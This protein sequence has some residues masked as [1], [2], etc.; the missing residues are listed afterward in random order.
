MPTIKLT[1][2]SGGR[3]TTVGTTDDAIVDGSLT[4]GDAD[5]DSLVVNAEF[6][7]DLVPDD[8]NTYDLGEATKRWRKGYFD[9]V[10]A[11]I[12]QAKSAKYRREDAT[13]QYIRWDSTGSNG[14]PGV[15][16]K[17]IA[18]VNGEL[19]TVILRATGTNSPVTPPGVTS[20]GFH[21]AANGAVNLDTTAVETKTIDMAAR[22]TSY[23]VA[24]DHPSFSAGEILGISI[25]PTDTPNDVNVTCIF[26]F[27]WSLLP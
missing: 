21:K 11:K 6:D 1:G 14:T 3:V 5:T 23:Q 12:P 22:N 19:V 17:L 7:S 13:L 26:L 25:N 18:P 24:F 4:I 2:F 10:I 16:N 20:I 9:E 8:D 27:D 15:N